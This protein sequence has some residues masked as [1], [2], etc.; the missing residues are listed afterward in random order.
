MISGRRKRA[1]IMAYG[2][3]HFNFQSYYSTIAAFTFFLDILGEFFVPVR[4]SFSAFN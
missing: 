4:F 1:I 2:R 3:L